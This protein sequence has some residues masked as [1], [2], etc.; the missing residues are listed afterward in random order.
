MRDSARSVILGCARQGEHIHL[1]Y[2]NEADRKAVTNPFKSS[3]V[4]K[5]TKYK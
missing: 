5:E 4:F 2:Y 1:G 3:K